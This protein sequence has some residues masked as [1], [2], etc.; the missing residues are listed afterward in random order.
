MTPEEEALSVG[1]RIEAYS[2]WPFAWHPLV[3]K[4][5]RKAH[6]QFI[7]SLY[8][9]EKFGELR[10]QGGGR[11]LAAITEK[12][13]KDARRIC[14]TCGKPCAPPTPPSL[15]RCPACESNPSLPPRWVEP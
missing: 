15:S 6:S 3:M 10:I 7:R 9:K 1:I 12:T 4:V 8:I 5:L 14:A 13:K 2:H 11:S